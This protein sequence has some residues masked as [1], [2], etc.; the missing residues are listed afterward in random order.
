MQAKT[1]NNLIFCTELK[2]A[3]RLESQTKLDLKDIEY[4]TLK[5]TFKYLYSISVKKRCLKCS[6]LKNLKNFIQDD[7]EYDICSTC[8]RRKKEKEL[9]MRTLMNSNIKDKI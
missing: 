7:I 5:P 9:V 1:T 8:Y 6:N 2:S 4:N 3:K